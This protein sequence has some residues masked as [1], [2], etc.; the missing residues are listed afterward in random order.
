M[1]GKPFLDFYNVH[2][3]AEESP[4]PL[5]SL[6]STVASMSSLATYKRLKS[7]VY[8]KLCKRSVRHSSILKPRIP[9]SSNPLLI[10][11]S[12][13]LV[14]ALVPSSSTST[15]PSFRR[16]TRNSSTSPNAPPRAR[17]A[18]K[19][20]RYTTTRHLFASICDLRLLIGVFLSTTVSAAVKRAQP[21]RRLRRC[22]ERVEVASL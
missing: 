17:K 10:P 13:F 21:L 11:S 1:P 5:Y 9:T 3:K 19:K 12:L 14:A 15:D 8:P 2:D 7:A 20:S 4:E 16:A 6:V 18:R 22:S